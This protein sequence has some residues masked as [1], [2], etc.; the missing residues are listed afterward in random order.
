MRS[1][2]VDSDSAICQID[3]R[4]SA[5]QHAGAFQAR[6][7]GTGNVRRFQAARRNF[8]QH[9]RKQPRIGLANC[10]FCPATNGRRI[11]L[12]KAQKDNPSVAEVIAR[13]IAEALSR[14]KNAKIWA[15]PRSAASASPKPTLPIAKQRKKLETIP[16]RRPIKV[17][18]AIDFIG[19]SLNMRTILD[20]PIPDQWSVLR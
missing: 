12:T 9:R 8:N 2:V 19:I 10:G 7:Q 16:Q 14:S 1:I 4:N 13:S 5:A 3:V 20:S 15:M 6:P 17:R 18:R 11:T